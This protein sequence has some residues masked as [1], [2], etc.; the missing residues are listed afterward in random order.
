M[1][2]WEPKLPG[3][4]PRFLQDTHIFK[5]LYLIR[6]TLTTHLPP[7]QGLLMF[8]FLNPRVYRSEADVCLYPCCF[9]IPCSSHPCLF[10]NYLS[11]SFPFRI[12]LRLF[13]VV[14]SGGTTDAQTPQLC[15][16]EHVFNEV[17]AVVNNGVQR[18]PFADLSGRLVR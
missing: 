10:V 1:E 12:I 7:S 4:P 9:S 14:Y 15:C 16:N 8:L 2:I 18:A 11:I 17:P 3:I 13:V 5:L 6:S